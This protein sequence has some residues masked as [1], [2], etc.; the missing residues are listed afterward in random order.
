[1]YKTLLIFSLLFVSVQTFALKPSKKYEAIP[2][3]LK[4]PYEKNDLLTPDK[5]NLKSWTFLP[6]KETDNHTTLVFA[7]ADAGNMSWWL[8]H[9]TILAQSG[10]TVVMFDYRGF[11]ESDSFAIDTK[12]LYYNEFTT[13]LSTVIKFA[14]TK[15]PANKTG[16]ISFSMGTI[17][18]TLA[19]KYCQP[20]F[21]IGEGYVTSPAKIKSYYAKKEKDII[22]PKGYDTYEKTL[23]DLK[24]PI[25]IFS[26]KKD[27]VTTVAAVKKLK[28]TK[29]QITLID[30]DGDHMQ[31]FTVMAKDY[32]G[33][34]YIEK[35]EHFLKIE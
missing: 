35:I 19:T 16:I 11:G 25:L 21:I 15:Y 8:M 3:T 17:I 22:L 6:A 29:P 7:Y 24:Q 33:S 32:P 20:D 23:K 12:M 2:D 26:G 4:L 28:T 10:F 27:E 31:G 30:F 9:A 13:D 18:A 5:V 34:V 14:K 1:M